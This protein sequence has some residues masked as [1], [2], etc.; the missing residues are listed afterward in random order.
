MENNPE[1][2][3]NNDIERNNRQNMNNP[4]IPMNTL[5]RPLINN[6][7]H[8]NN[9]N[10]N[11]QGYQNPQAPYNNFNQP[12]NFNLN[13]QFQGTNQMPYVPSHPGQGQNPNDIA[14][15]ND[16]SRGI[17][18][19]NDTRVITPINQQ[20]THNKPLNYNTQSNNNNPQ[21]TTEDNKL[22]NNFAPLPRHSVNIK[23]GGC[24]SIGYTKVNNKLK[25]SVKTCLIVFFIISLIVPPLLIVFCCYLCCA[26]QSSNFAHVHTC[27]I[28]HH[29]I[30]TS[31][32]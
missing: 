2:G 19:G 27:N 6:Q 11:L 30:G 10:Y 8:L 17:N 15:M 23:C 16:V 7:E 5:N 21:F 4:N 28:C 18:P 31:Y 32:Y 12:Q 29:T 3:P 9:A 20:N 26:F 14:I 1:F 22:Y 25:T 13:N 24:N